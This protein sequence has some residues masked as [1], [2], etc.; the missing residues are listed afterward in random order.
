MDEH[1]GEQKATTKAHAVH[2]KKL[3]IFAKKIDKIKMTSRISSRHRTGPSA[4]V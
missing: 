3:N 1:N 2:Q 4:K